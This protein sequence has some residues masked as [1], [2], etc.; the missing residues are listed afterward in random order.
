MSQNQSEKTKTET[1]Q[2]VKAPLVRMGNRL[3]RVGDTITG[4][5]ARTKYLGGHL[6]KAKPVPAPVQDAEAS[7]SKGQKA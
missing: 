1:T 2:T 4:K 5:A 7:K 3:V 6:G